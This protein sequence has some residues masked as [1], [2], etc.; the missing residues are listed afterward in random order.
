MRLKAL[1]AAAA[2][3][4]ISVAFATT[5]VTRIHARGHATNSSNTRLYFQLNVMH[6]NRDSSNRYVGQGSFAWTA[7]G[8]TQSMRIRSIRAI[9]VEEDDEA[10]VVRIEGIGQLGRWGFAPGRFNSNLVEGDF[11]AVFTDNSEG[12]DS[13]SF[14]FNSGSGITA[15]NYSFSGTVQSGSTLDVIRWTL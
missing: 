4:L 1:S 13:L 6:I 10:R 12:N 2:L 11:I 15:F 14:S 8:R 7:N 9:I 3:I 5:V